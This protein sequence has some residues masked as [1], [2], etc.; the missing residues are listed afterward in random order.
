MP[1]IGDHD[2][3]TKI[4]RQIDAEL[5]DEA[6]ALARQASSCVKSLDRRRLERASRL[7]PYA[8]PL[9]GLVLGL[10]SLVFG[11]TAPE[12]NKPLVFSGRLESSTGER[13]R[14]TAAFVAAVAQ[15]EGVLPGSAGHQA[16][17]RVRMVHASV[18][19][20]IWARG[21]F[22]VERWG[23]PINQHDMLATTLLFSAVLV[24]GLRMLG[25]KIDDAWADDWLYLWRAASR[26]LGVEDDILPSR[27]E[28]ALELARTIFAVQGAVDDDSRR[29]VHALLDFPARAATTRAQ[30]LRAKALRRWSST[31]CRYL[32]G[33][34]V[35]DALQLEPLRPRLVAHVATLGLRGTIGMTELLRAHSS[36]VAARRFQAG[37][38]LWAM[39]LRSQP[40]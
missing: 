28:E 16:A 12:G 38:Q 22:D 24:D 15:P 31:T 1:G 21:G 18:R 39:H 25:M 5:C 27:H 2:L 9:A 36:V 37:A 23:Q 33:D 6:R 13:L 3:I 17:L 30:R 14:H 34:D 11:F 8:G 40:M 10:R 7:L 35:A 26:V 4:S 19:R 20:A 32:V 29:L